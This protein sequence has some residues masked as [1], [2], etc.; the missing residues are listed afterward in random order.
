MQLK[1]KTWDKIG[2]IVNFG[3]A[4]LCILFLAYRIVS[5]FC[6]KNVTVPKDKY[7]L[8]TSEINIP[9]YRQTTTSVV[10]KQSAGY[11]SSPLPQND[12][13]LNIVANPTFSLEDF[14]LIG[15]NKENV[16]L[17]DIQVYRYDPY[18]RSVFTDEYG[19]L[20][21]MRLQSIYHKATEWMQRLQKEV[22]HTEV[23]PSYHRDNIFA[24]PEQRRQGP[25]YEL[26]QKIQ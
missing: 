12:L 1:Q 18:I 22:M 2:G 7:E 10:Q 3:I 9:T 20:N 19:N 5:H 21:E 26:T 24:L 14:V 23:E 25:D 13:M 16:S 11:Q 8:K 15:V 17:R 4:I 6:E